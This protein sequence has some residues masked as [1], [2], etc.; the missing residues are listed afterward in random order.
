MMTPL[1]RKIT[2]SETPDFQG[3]PVQDQ[4]GNLIGYVV[5]DLPN[6]EACLAMVSS[7]RL[8]VEELKSITHQ[9]SIR[10]FSFNRENKHDGHQRQTSGNDPFLAPARRTRKVDVVGSR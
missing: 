4:S 5:R 2:I 8:S 9:M 7:S 3:Y 10:T 1:Q 6:L